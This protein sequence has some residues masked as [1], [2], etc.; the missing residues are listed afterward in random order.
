MN[1]GIDE[2]DQ[3]FEDK[4]NQ[5]GD[6]V[7]PE[8]RTLRVNLDGAMMTTKLALHFMRKDG[9]GGSIVLSGSRASEFSVGY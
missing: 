8:W 6:P 1:A 4:I 5:N 3:P 7:E 9:R 2:S